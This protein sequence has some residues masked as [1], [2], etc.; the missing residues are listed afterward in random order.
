ME[1]LPRI[2]LFADT[3]HEL[4]GAANFLRRLAGFAKER[5]YPFLCVR[6]GDETGAE[7]DGSVTFLNIKRGRGSIP[8]D[9]SLRYDPFMWRN[10]AFVKKELKEFNPCGLHLTGLNDVS[11]LGFMHA[12]RSELPAV[13]TWHTNAHE[14]AATRLL[15]KLPW[16]PEKTADR[17]GGVIE[18]TTMKG[19]MKLYF[20]AQ[21]QLA[22]NP[23]L[24][25]QIRDLTKRPSY[26]LRRGVDTDF[27]NPNKRD[28]SN[29]EIVLGF[30]GRLRP[31][32]N[33]RMLAAIEKR[34]IAEGLTNYRFLVVGEG[35]ERPWLTA[36]LK[37]AEFTGEIHGDELARA[38]ANMD[39]FVFPSLTDAFANVVLEAMSSG[40]PA[41]SF[42]VGGPKFL[43]EDNVSGLIAEDEPDLAHKIAAVIR[44][45]SM[46]EPMRPKAR[47]FAEEHSWEHIFEK[48]YEF[49]RVLRTYKKNVR[50]KDVPLTFP[51]PAS[52]SVFEP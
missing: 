26:L 1:I 48:T 30:V 5:D 12:H 34:L 19:L 38:F 43:I 42:A 21:M 32:K 10:F 35:N 40:V 23:E 29:D 15:S 36:N 17:L 18:R 28:R 25:D 22:P 3:Y 11:Q 4:N 14:Y 39:L 52:S 2:A 37:R 20:L 51:E 47:A 50:A 16:I 9:G 41:I 33:V 44:N 27:L 46:I 13:A 49:Y 8:L 45:P 31:E 7:Q 6:A 24:V